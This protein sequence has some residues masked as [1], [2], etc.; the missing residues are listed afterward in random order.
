MCYNQGVKTTVDIATPL[1]NDIKRYASANGLTLRQVI[2]M[3]LRQTLAASQAKSA[4]FRL[5]K[6]TFKGDGLAAD[7][8]WPTIRR[9]IYEG[10]GG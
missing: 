8:D 5:R 6:C 9:Q 1:L 2:E 4:P 7:A 3:G 10:R